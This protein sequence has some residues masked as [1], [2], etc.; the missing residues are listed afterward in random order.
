MTAD[1]ILVEAIQDILHRYLGYDWNA[2][3]CE[4]LLRLYHA[5]EYL[6]EQKCG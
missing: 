2:L 6:Q 3:E 5:R 4:A 1:Q